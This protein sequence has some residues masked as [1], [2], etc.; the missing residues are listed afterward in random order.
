VRVNWELFMNVQETLLLPLISLAIGTVLGTELSRYIYRPKVK[1]RYKDIDP[2]IDQTGVYWSIQIENA[3]R[4]VAQDCIAT[5]SL[6]SISVDDIVSSQDASVDENLPK[7]VGENIDLETP[8]EQILKVG[9]FREIRRTSLC[10]AKLGNPDSISINPGV[11]ATL[12]ICK[13]QKSQ[14]RKYFI[15]PSEDGWRRVRVRLQKN[16]LTGYILICPS[17]EF[18]TRVNIELTVDDSG[19]SKLDVKRPGF[20]QRIF[21]RFED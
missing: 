18:P 19:E 8:R 10:W 7:Y 1:V 2:N 21:R 3:G 5:I 11:S 15:F 12:D 6:F 20:F 4:C 13:F 14:D 9:H 17:N 16:K